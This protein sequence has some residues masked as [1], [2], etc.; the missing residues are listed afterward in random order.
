MI[1]ALIPIVC[2]V[3]LFV[4]VFALIISSKF[5]KD[6]IGGEGEVRFF[7]LL[8]V[9][10]AIIIVLCGLFLGTAIYTSRPFRVSKN[11]ILLIQNNLSSDIQGIHLIADGLKSGLESF[12]KKTWI[13]AFVQDTI[14]KGGS[15]ED[16]LVELEEAG[17]RE[18]KE[19][20][21]LWFADEVASVVIQTRK[22]M[23]PIERWR[24]EKTI[25]IHTHYDRMLIA[26]ASQDSATYDRMV[27]DAP[28]ILAEAHMAMEDIAKFLTIKS[29]DRNR[30]ID[31]EGDYR[32]LK[33]LLTDF[34]SG[35]SLVG[36]DAAR[37]HI[38]VSQAP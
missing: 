14:N 31:V 12:L 26:V 23:E 25:A 4:L 20:I 28:E 10:G 33:K 19:E 30:I 7:R 15:D 21:L 36:Q 1:Q 38:V 34:A 3:I 11:E 27:K 13:R 6:V 5:R 8:T 16:P 29:E 22:L 2:M 9:K 37:P 35:A 17:S 32:D 18:E 24:D